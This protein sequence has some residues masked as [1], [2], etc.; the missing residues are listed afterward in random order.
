MKKYKIL[1]WGLV[2][3]AGLTGC[4]QTADNAEQGTEAAADEAEAQTAEASE[5]E[6]EEI[7]LD[8]NTGG[9]P[10]A[11]SSDELIYGGDPSAMVDGDTVYLY[12]GHDASTDEEVENS[13][14]NIPEYFCYS[15]T[16]MINW[17]SEGVVMTMDTVEWAKDDT[18]AWASQVIKHYDEEAQ[19]DKYY[20]Y[21]CSWDKSGKQ[22]IGVAVADS[23][24]GPFTDI[25]EPIVRGGKTKPNTS[26]YNDID[27][28]VWVETDEDGTEHRYLAWGNGIFFV[29]ELNPDMISVKDQNGDGEITSGKVMGECDIVLKTTGLDSYT[30]APWL[31]RR[32]D[33]NG[34][35]YGDYYLFFANGWRENMAYAVTDDLINGDWSLTNI[36]MMPTTTSNTNHMAV[37]DF[38]GE[39]YFI[40]HN[41]SL[42]AGSG[43]RRSACVVKLNFNDDGSISLFEESASGLS[44]DHKE[45][46]TAAGE[47]ISHENFTNSSADS[48]Y[49]YKDISVSTASTDNEK[50][51]EWVIRPGKADSSEDTYVSIES[52][53][54]PGLYMTVSDGN[55]VLSQDTKA[56][57]STAAKQTF[58]TVSALDGSDG[59]SFMSV[60]D[61]NMYITVVDGAL[62]LTDGSDAENAVFFIN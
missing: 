56:D 30:E 59:V 52:E 11:G 45:I 50:D 54:K 43:F 29:C 53:N 20:L 51:S 21:Y 28:T 33:E 62:V 1:V 8:K 6:P 49:P 7:V 55:I 31:Y 46:T 40:Y 34:N 44:G 12:T 39:T 22:S 5:A 27:P 25:G 18:S 61:E 35:Y 19:A 38:K 15:S 47:K 58:R 17:K 24:T 37:I 16:D 4:G 14:Y 57:E 36:I 3:A 32:Q 10:L 9:N 2:M 13:V 26:T 23:P 48:D 41:G 60:S 42:P